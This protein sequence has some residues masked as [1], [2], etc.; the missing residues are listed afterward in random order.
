MDF[1]KIKTYPIAQRTNKFRLA[2][3][4]PLDAPAA[5]DEQDP[6]LAEVAARIVEARHRGRRVILMIGGA[7]V[8]EGCSRLLIDLMAR[9]V[10]DHVAGNG[11][12]SIHDFELAMIGATSEDVADGLQ[13]GTFGMAE[14]TGRLMNESL[15]DGA[16][17]GIGYGR[18]VAEKI[19]EQAFAHRADS[20]LYNALTLSIPV[21]IHVAIGGD[22]VHQH[23][24]C[25]GAALGAT[26]YSDFRL[27]IESV[28]QLADGVLL[29]IGS[30][31][32]L[33]EVFLKALTIA[34]NLGH[35]VRG[36]TTAN[37][38]FLDMY[39]ARTRI[40]EWPRVLGCRGYDVRG[41]HR[42]TLPALHRLV[43][44][45]LGET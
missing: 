23:P 25:D 38:D 26:S 13:D 28:A 3:M 34:R 37:F 27:L 11:A 31:V 22:I 2:D 7:V 41:P 17:R 12:V 43:L 33:P 14:E 8:K 16:A 18:A 6:L 30:A 45:G 1:T 9:G 10:I 32:L 42:K 36:F 4:L 40:V 29:N 21:T 44:R 19:A 20:L 24:T 5:G 39:R 35:D 15:K